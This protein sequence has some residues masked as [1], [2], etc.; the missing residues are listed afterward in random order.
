[1]PKIVYNQLVAMPPIDS[2]HCN[3]NRLQRRFPQVFPPRSIAAH[4][5]WANAR[6]HPARVRW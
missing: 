3:I 5:L 2:Y 1:M 6:P 4:T